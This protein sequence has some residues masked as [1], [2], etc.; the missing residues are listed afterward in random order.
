MLHPKNLIVSE[1]PGGSPKTILV[2]IIHIP[3]D[4]KV[5]GSGKESWL[6]KSNLREEL[7]NRIVGCN[8]EKPPISVAHSSLE[9]LSEDSLYKSVCPA[10]RDGV[11]LVCRDQRTFELVDHDRC[12]LCGQLFIYTDIEDL[13]KGRTNG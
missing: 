8:M 10:C 9:R 4:M 2:R 13:R 6:V 1:V 12:I 11:L 5:S 7:I 3:T